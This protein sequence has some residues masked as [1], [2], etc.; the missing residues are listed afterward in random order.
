MWYL[1]MMSKTSIP[2]LIRIDYS[3]D[4]NPAHGCTASHGFGIGQYG[5]TVALTES[6][7]G[8]LFNLAF[9]SSPYEFLWPL[10][11]ISE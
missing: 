5:V 2:W 8:I 4:R 11:P 7:A 9:T 3:Q 6:P 1:D 10:A